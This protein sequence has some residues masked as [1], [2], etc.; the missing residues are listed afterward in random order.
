MQIFKKKTYLKLFCLLAT[1]RGSN[2]DTI[3][4]VFP[5]STYADPFAFDTTFSFRTEIRNWKCRSEWM[6]FHLFSI[7]LQI[8][9][10]SANWRLSCRCPPANVVASF[11]WYVCVFCRALKW[12]GVDSGAGILFKSVA[13]VFLPC[14][15]S[16]LIRFATNLINLK[17]NKCTIEYH[18]GW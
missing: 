15:A 17:C 18:A 6:H 9:R 11:S 4:F 12:Y 2:T 13:I 7:N 1:S 3:T 16:D 14:T 8:F 10:A 5:I